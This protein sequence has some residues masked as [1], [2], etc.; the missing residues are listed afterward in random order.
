MKAVLLFLLVCV[1]ALC[2][3]SRPVSKKKSDVDGEFEEWKLKYEKSYS[4][5]EEEARRKQQWLKSR[6]MVIEH[7]K[8]AD[9]GE[10]TY[11]MAVNHFA[12]RVRHGSTAP[13]SVRKEGNTVEIIGTILHV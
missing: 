3:T 11:W 6:A 5:P 8:K 13:P 12:D 10:E 4:S 9:A 7:N 1:V 2:V